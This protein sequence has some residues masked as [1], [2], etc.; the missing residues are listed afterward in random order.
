M[1]NVK[2]DRNPPLRLEQSVSRR[3]LCWQRAG[4]FGYLA[5]KK[6][7]ETAD[8]AMNFRPFWLVSVFWAAL[9]DCSPL[10]VKEPEETFSPLPEELHPSPQEPGVFQIVEIPSEFVTYD[11]NKDGSISLNELSNITETNENDAIQPFHTADIDGNDLL[12]KQEFEVAPWV[13]HIPEDVVNPVI[14]DEYGR[15]LFE[16]KHKE[17]E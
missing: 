9:A 16:K 13:F 15:L 12:T 11:V 4:R 10:P 17:V 3:T 14:E 6:K 2:V 1:G 5:R 8:F 7:F